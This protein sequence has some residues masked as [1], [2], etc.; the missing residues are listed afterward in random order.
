MIKLNLVW[1]MIIVIITAIIT[2]YSVANFQD[3][4]HN[5]ELANLQN[6]ADQNVM[7]ERIIA[8]NVGD[9]FEK[10]ISDTSEEMKSCFSSPTA[11]LSAG[12]PE[13]DVSDCRVCLM[14]VE[15]KMISSWPRCNDFFR[16]DID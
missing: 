14:E 15:T 2:G 9:C 1:V 5:G 11:C 16:P 3:N 6:I 7:K 13:Y 12:D 4:A 10:L 8:D